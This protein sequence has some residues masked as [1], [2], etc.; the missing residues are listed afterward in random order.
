[1]CVFKY[2]AFIFLERPPPW[3]GTFLS[4]RVLGTFAH[5]SCFVRR[6]PMYQVK[7]RWIVFT[8][9]PAGVS[10]MCKCGGGRRPFSGLPAS[11]FLFQW[12]Y[13]GSQGM[14][15]AQRKA[16]QRHSCRVLLPT[17]WECCIWNHCTVS[18]LWNVYLCVNVFFFRCLTACIDPLSM[19]WRDP[20]CT[21]NSYYPLII[22]Y[23]VLVAF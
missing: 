2:H 19:P 6:L 23:G 15:A 1:M 11:W 21:R 12:Q 13:I 10:G 4:Q 8:G 17:E 14:E 20:T 22:C 9:D 5:S 16:A 7:G 18:L 3:Y